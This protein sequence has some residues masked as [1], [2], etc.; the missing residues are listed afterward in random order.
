MEDLM[1]TTNNNGQLVH[2]QPIGT[3]ANFNHYLFQD[4]IQKRLGEILQDKNKRE[5][6]NNIVINLVSSNADLQNCTP[7]SIIFASLRAFELN[8]NISL[9]EAWIIRYGN[10]KTG[11]SNAQYQMGCKGFMQLA[12]RSGRYSDVNVRDVREGEYLGINNY[13]GAHEFRFIKDTKHREGL[14]IIG[15][16][17]FLVSKDGTAQ[18]HFMTIA[19]LTSHGQ[20]Y[21]KT[22]NFTSGI[23]KTHTKAM[24]EKTIIKQLLSKKA[25]L[26]IDLQTAIQSDQS[27]MSDYNKYE[28]VD[29]QS[30]A[31]VSNLEE[32]L[33]EISAE[34][35]SNEK[36]VLDAI[37]NFVK[38]DED[39]D[40]IF[41]NSKTE[42]ALVD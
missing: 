22:F 30:S 19:E 35:F 40:A 41:S 2:Q 3:L 9:G 1:S 18:N 23:W 29:N 39:Y 36:D 16:V 31:S 26:S 34:D 21:S 4:A 42:S 38:A 6:F 8:L 14:T 32:R 33:S 10:S 20:K 27:V 25:M 15:Y 24:Y 5:R 28:Y 7:T 11:T 17:G 37:D 13:T 12:L